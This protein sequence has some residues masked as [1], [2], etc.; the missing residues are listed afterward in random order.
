[1]KSRVLIGVLVLTAIATAQSDRKYMKSPL[2]AQRNLPFSSAVQAGNTLFIAGTT[3]ET[4]RLAKG[5]SPEDEAKSIMEQIKKTIESA[6][7]TMD[8]LVS[9]QVYCTDLAM[10]D[11]FNGV[12]RQ[13]F[14]TNYPSRAFVGVAKL[15][16]GAHFEVAGTAVKR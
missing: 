4:E 7:M 15:L 10:Y 12:Y 11:A 14:R 1:M 3:A 6:G 16:F 13:Y 8:D 2:A 9:V 5:L